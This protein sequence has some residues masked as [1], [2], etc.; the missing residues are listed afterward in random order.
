MQ[1]IESHANTPTIVY[2]AKAHRAKSSGDFIESIDYDL[3][4]IV[5]SIYSH[6]ILWL[7]HINPI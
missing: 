5:G 7:F 2:E 1:G 6:C 3:V 4:G